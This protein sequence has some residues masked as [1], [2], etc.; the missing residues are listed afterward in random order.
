MNNLALLF[1]NKLFKFLYSGEEIE[2][3]IKGGITFFSVLGK[4]SSRNMNSGFFRIQYDITDKEFK[5]IEVTSLYF[6]QP[7]SGGFFVG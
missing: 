3:N 2:C 1:K 7:Q 4:N 5:L 6:T